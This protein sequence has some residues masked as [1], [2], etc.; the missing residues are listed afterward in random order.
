MFSTV[1]RRAFAFTS[2]TLSFVVSRPVLGAQTSAAASR[3]PDFAAVDAYVARELAADRLPGV[4]IAIVH[5]DSIVHV[6]GFG[7]DGHC[8]PR[9]PVTA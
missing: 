9:A 8:R 7:D 2:L 6:H 4:S 5:G 1:S 3:T